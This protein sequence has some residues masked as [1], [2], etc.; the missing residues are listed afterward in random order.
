MTLILS[1]FASV[2]FPLAQDEL[3]FVRNWG[4]FC[5]FLVVVLWLPKHVLSSL[6]TYRHVVVASERCYRILTRMEV[7]LV[8]RVKVLIL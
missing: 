3:S 1:F 4:F 7:G 8:E 5:I 2:S 6:R